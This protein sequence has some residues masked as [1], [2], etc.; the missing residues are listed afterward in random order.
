L[1][2]GFWS[3]HRRL[4]GAA[5]LLIAAAAA[6]WLV[7]AVLG[8]FVLAGVL[9]YLLN[10]L[11]GTLARRGFSRLAAL[12]FV[13]VVVILAVV[14]VVGLVVPTVVFELGR[15]ADF[16]PGF[17][18]NLQKMAFDFQSRYSQAQ[19][20]QP[21]RQA[22]D[23]AIFT[24]QTRLLRLV[25]A[26]AQGV[27]AIFPALFSILLAPILS[28]Y[29][30]KDLEYF[31]RRV[32]ALIPRP[33]RQEAWDILSEVD[34]VVSGFIR[35]QL[36]VASLVGLLVVVG[37]T[38]LGIRF[39]VILGIFA[40]MAEVIPYFGPLIGALPA[41]AV[42]GTV[43]A[44]D[45]LKVAA[46]MGGI[47]WLES[48]MLSPRVLGSRV[49]LHPVAVIFALLVGFELFGILGMVAAVPVA[50]VVRVLLDHALAS[51]SPSG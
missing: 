14:V 34:Q 12:T 2:T 43:S 47:Q 11:V 38:A 24:V 20:P 27:L 29:F 23:D 33:E 26:A 22:V 51:R 32:R 10:P 15:L 4:L 44:L 40:G 30:L 45:A 7:R 1:L 49:G 37:L 3:R 8:P 13:Y 16:L 9:S 50:G 48:N 35:G 28:F 39:A 5:F 41:L 31:R 25:S 6:L 17:F 42:A 18:A 19:L 46:M 36:I 21:V